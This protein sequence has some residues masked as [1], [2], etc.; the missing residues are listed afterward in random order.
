[1]HRIIAL[2][3][4]N[5]A[6][7]LVEVQDFAV[8]LQLDPKGV[9]AAESGGVWARFNGT[10]IGALLLAILALTLELFNCWRC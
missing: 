8:P 2:Q 4:Q 10:F 5:L 6:T 3:L 7:P 1:M 9:E